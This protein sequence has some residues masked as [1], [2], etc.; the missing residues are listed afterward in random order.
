MNN[1]NKL[2]LSTIVLVLSVS[3]VIC[4]SAGRIDAQEKPVD[5]ATRLFN[6]SGVKFTKVSDNVWSVPFSG[7]NLKEFQVAVA[8]GDDILVM[9]VTL[10][11]AKKLRA[12]PEMMKRLLLLNTEYDR[13]K[14]GFDKG[15]DLIVRTDLGIR[16]LDKLEFQEN[17]DQIAAAADGLF[18]TVKPFLIQAR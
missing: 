7:K 6:E 11:E 1:F 14:I 13:V 18:S 9:F 8:T 15:G 12:T 17:L 4:F 3:T 16:V 10:A 5:K 2:L